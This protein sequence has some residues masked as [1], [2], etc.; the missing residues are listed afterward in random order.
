LS[1][2]LL[3]IA[4]E[5][6]V[7]ASCAKAATTTDIAIRAE[8]Q[9]TPVA[10]DASHF[11]ELAA[12]GFFDSAAEA[13]VEKALDDVLSGL[14]AVEGLEDGGHVSVGLVSRGFASAEFV[15]LVEGA[16]KA[17]LKAEAKGLIRARL[18]G[19]TAP[20]DEF[21]RFAL[22]AVAA[23]EA[24]LGLVYRVVRER[25]RAVA[26]V[27]VDERENCVHVLEKSPRGV[28]VY[29][30]EVVHYLYY[31]VGDVVYGDARAEGVVVLVF[32]GGEKTI[33]VEVLAKSVVNAPAR[34][35]EVEWGGER[36]LR[37]A[38]AKIN[39]V[40][41]A[42]NYVA[43]IRVK[44]ERLSVEVSNDSPASVEGLRGLLVTDA[45]GKEIRTPDPL[46][47]KTFA[48][49]FKRVR[50]EVAGVSHTEA[51]PA[52]VFKAVALDGKPFEKLF[53]DIAERYGVELWNVVEKAKGMWLETLYKLRHDISRVAEEA[54]EV[55]RREG[56]EAGRRTLV[57]GLSRL[58]EEREKEALNAGRLDDALAIAVA[59]RL[60]LGI[61]NSPR[62]WLSLLVG[63]GVVNVAHKR[64]GFSAKYAEVAEVVLRL[65]VAWVGAYRAG[66]RVE[67]ENG[68]AVYADAEDAAK[69]LK[70]VLSGEVLE[71]ATSLARSWNGL[72]GSDAPKLISL[73]ALAQLLGV[74][75]GRWAVELWLAHKAATIPTLPWWPRRLIG[76]SP[77][78][79]EWTKWSGLRE[80]ST[81]T[82]NYVMWRPFLGWP[83]LGYTQ[84]FAT[85]VSTATRVARRRRGGFLRR[86][87]SGSA[88]RW[89]S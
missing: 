51:G 5:D 56:I 29:K 4:L 84:T 32:L 18:V 17:K 36:R 19:K 74:V 16:V 75:E 47:I 44:L 53:E 39:R 24:A 55:G 10:V 21:D 12:S 50:I 1:K 49:R 26:S 65:L 71:N 40:G 30:R 81:S 87:L 83:R 2:A 20:R 13:D 86:W 67:K 61:V 37:L 70:V 77:E 54:A 7:T 42:G 27:D 82:S 38:I 15:R 43:E 52:L 28:K 59:G 88:P 46:L 68:V 85:S 79:R 66:I 63:D 25:W 72:A 76:S 69:V 57:E 62:E 23:V 73:L 35:E 6:H 31:E 45:F 58:F 34:F 33:R 8:V 78:W 14:R 64:L 22:N 3:E 60:M 80:V 41:G 89:C 48:S 11:A 9:P